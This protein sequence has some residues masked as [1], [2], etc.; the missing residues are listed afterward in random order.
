MASI[1]TKVKNNKYG[2]FKNLKFMAKSILRFDK[3]LIFYLP[4][5][6]IAQ[7]GISILSIYIPKIIIDIL[8]E[9]ASLSRLLISISVITLLLIAFR[10]LLRLGDIQIS[11]RSMSHR[12]YANIP[13]NIKTVNCDYEQIAHK[14]GQ[15]K[16]RKALNAVLSNDSGTEAIVV[17]FA[18]VLKN[19]G[20]L[21]IYAVILATLNPYVAIYLIAGAGISL[22]AAKRS[23][24]YEH[25]HKKDTVPIDNK[26]MYMQEKTIEGKNAKDIRIYSMVGW[27]K[28]LYA[29]FI[30]QSSTWEIKLARHKFVPNAVDSIII[31]LRDGLAYVYLIY[32]VLN[33]LSVGDFV[34]FFGAITGFSIWLSG[35]VGNINEI[36]RASLEIS[37]LREFTDMQDNTN[38]GQG[39]KLPEATEL[40]CDIE[41][42]NVSY[43]YPDD[44][45][46]VI[47]N[48]SLKISKGERLAIVGVNG[49][50]KTTI[51][52][53]LCGLILPTEGVVLLNSK[54]MH[55]YN[56]KDYQSLFSVAFQ[57]ALIASI[58]LAENI[59][60]E[61]VE[62]I[63]YPK[64]DIAIKKANLKE[65]IDSL[66]NGTKTYIS[67]IFTDDGIELSGGEKQKLILARAL[68]KDAPILI[69]DEP[70][71][72]LDPIAESRLY[73]RY[74][75]MSKEKTSVYIS[76]RLAS[77]RFCDEI[78]FLEDGK[79]VESGSHDELM[80]QNRKYAHMY[81]VQSHY[82]K[83]GE[84]KV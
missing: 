48:L 19:T 57:D 12:V 3:W 51:V 66:E 20:G 43:K 16:R 23:I 34:L 78:I 62:K 45:N 70:T 52:K 75:E 55:D 27:L 46:Y 18:E 71:A 53:L 49:V 17:Q 25:K 63:D 67:N 22:L 60:M 69:L 26:I 44:D 9:D 59:A 8:T 79:I 15:E 58:S 41:L 39:C 36:Q 61:P 6:M 74:V 76:H 38:R 54:P 13:I 2:I 83:E 35:I 29:N 10:L 50:G 5:P 37:D 65:K 82:Y 68:Y 30:A 32:R 72:A 31:V 40:P 4:F 24:N 14:E 56:L 77:T 1:T 11:G 28:E 81:E 84:I 42:K 33:G 7:L 80:R 64:V 47:K 73:E 21:I